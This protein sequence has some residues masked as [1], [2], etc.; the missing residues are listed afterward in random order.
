[1]KI[2]QQ[3]LPRSGMY[4]VNSFVWQ[5]SRFHSWNIFMTS[6]NRGGVH[7][8]LF[9]FLLLR[10]S[11]T[12]YSQT[13]VPHRSSFS[14]YCIPRVCIAFLQ[15]HLILAPTGLILE[16]DKSRESI[17]F[18]S[19]RHA[20]YKVERIAY[21]YLTSPVPAEHSSRDLLYGLLLPAK[22]RI[23]APRV[24]LASAHTGLCV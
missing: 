17:L 11:N 9:T 15:L 5:V 8:K 16:H 6:S 19:I 10:R 21:L 24:T 22:L 1:M 7:V 14:S 20:R 13:F 12:L 3:P 4:K 18:F 2:M 23:R